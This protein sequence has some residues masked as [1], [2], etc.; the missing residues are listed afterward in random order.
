MCHTNEELIFMKFIHIQIIYFCILLVSNFNIIAETPTVAATTS[1]TTPPASTTPAPTTATP[2]VTTTATPPATTPAPATTEKATTP[3]ASP[4]ATPA[5]ATTTP[6][7]TPTTSTTSTTPAP[8]PATTTPP[9]TPA[10]TT[11][12]ATTTTPPVTPA[13]ATPPASTTPT[14][15]TTAEVP[16]VQEKTKQILISVYIQNNYTQDAILNKIELLITDQ[17]TPLIKDNLKIPIQA[18]KSIYSKGSVTAFDLTAQANSIA[19]FNG[20]Q[21]ITIG[22]DQIVFTNVRTGISLSNPI[23]ITKQNDKWVLDKK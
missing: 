17:T 22:E 5:P 13:T 1:P 19:S 23:Q 10:A 16:V 20:I 4:A 6:T 12:A 11:P 2:P 18:S 14:P 7:A 3:A 15:T 9:T 21:S 8:T